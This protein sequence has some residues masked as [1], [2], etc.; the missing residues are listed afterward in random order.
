MICSHLDYG[1]LGYRC[2][3]EARIKRDGKWYCGIHDPGKKAPKIAERNARWDAEH[4]ANRKKMRL[5]ASASALLEALEAFIYEIT[6]AG[7]AKLAEM[8][9]GQ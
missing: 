2:H 4:E 8:E 6:P 7:R 9:K 3:H 1:K 5:I